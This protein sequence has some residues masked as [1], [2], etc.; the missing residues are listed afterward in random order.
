MVVTHLVANRLGELPS[1][2]E[3]RP[4]PSRSIRSK[5][6][7]VDREQCGDRFSC[8]TNAQQEGA[9]R[10]VVGL[11]PP[12]ASYRLAPVMTMERRRRKASFLV[13]RVPATERPCLGRGCFSILDEHAE[14]RP[15]ER[16]PRPSAP[17]ERLSATPG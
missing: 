16:G 3:I 7:V 8:A 10:V 1:S 15:N 6:R 14:D 13:D 17:A 4:S 5:V 12:R 2:A 11:T 9:G